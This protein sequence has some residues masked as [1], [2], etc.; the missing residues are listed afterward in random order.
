M[1]CMWL[2]AAAGR[3]YISFEN[4]FVS[5]PTNF[6]ILMI[7]SVWQQMFSSNSFR[8]SFYSSITKQLFANTSSSAWWHGCWLELQR[9]RSSRSGILFW[10]T[11]LTN[12]WS[13]TMKG[14][15]DPGMKQQLYHLRSTITSILSFGL[16][17]WR[18]G[19]KILGGVC[20]RNIFN[21]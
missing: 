4:K 6:G 13:S 18:E 7:M 19:G 1:M 14:R 12:T 21:V 8:N 3:T 16:S 11:R 17:G 10:T 20:A 5:R 2:A 15:R 9:W